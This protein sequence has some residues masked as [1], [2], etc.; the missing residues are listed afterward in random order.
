MKIIFVQL[1]GWMATTLDDNNIGGQ[2]Y[3]MRTT[4]V[5]NRSDD[6]ILRQQ[7]LMTAMLDENNVGQ[8]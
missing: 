3:W 2:Q 6:D 8:L 7:H 5:G 1:K 4:L